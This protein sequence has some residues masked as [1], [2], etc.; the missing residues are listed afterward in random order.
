MNPELLRDVYQL[1]RGGCLQ[2]RRELRQSNG[3]GSVERISG[4]RRI[5]VPAHHDEHAAAPSG[6]LP[7]LHHRLRSAGPAH[8]RHRHQCQCWIWELQWCVCIIKMND[9][10]GL[11]AQSN[12]TWSKA[13]GMGAFAQATSQYTAED[14][15]NLKQMYGRQGYD[16]K[17][18]YNMFVVYSPPFYKGQHGLMGRVLGGWTIAGI[19]T[20]GSG[21]PN[22]FTP[23][24]AV[25]KNLAPA[26]TLTS[27]ATRMRCQS[28]RFRVD[29]LTSTRP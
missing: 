3:V 20:A 25:A 27:S 18:V 22:R 2:R 10:H 16:R 7:R 21:T 14:V 1:Y 6:T 8:I 24:P 29:M 5:Q 17:F 12:F 19:F 26:I 11:T 23:R 28:G 9:W 15:F 13:L 4:Q